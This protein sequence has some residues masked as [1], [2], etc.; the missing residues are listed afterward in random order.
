MQVTEE[1]VAPVELGD[2]CSTL[3]IPGRV[4]QA[5]PVGLA[6]IPIWGTAVPAGQV[7][8]RVAM[9]PMHSAVQVVGAVTARVAWAALA[10]SVVAPMRAMVQDNRQP[11]L[12]APAAMASAVVLVVP[13][14][15]GM[16]IPVPAM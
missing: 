8:L 4:Q 14:E 9:A 16:R 15:M 12:A 3:S 11:V 6:E 10:V 13:G 5:E 2:F 1:L 7:D